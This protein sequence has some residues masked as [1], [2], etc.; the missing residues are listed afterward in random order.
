MSLLVKDLM[1]R[2]VVTLEADENLLLADDV[3][4]LGRIRHL[5]VVERGELVGLVSHRD[6]LRSSVSSIAGL[7]HSEDATIKR[8]IPV[9]EV[10]RRDVLTVTAD[11]SA[12]DAC[13][14]ILE[15]KLGC[16]PVVDGGKRLVGILTEADFVDLAR[17]YLE[18]LKQ[19]QASKL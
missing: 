1:T 6:I 18:G 14:L 13:R 5:P 19:D 8:A 9:R 7:S 3:M 2:D 4:R 16:L 10:M 17:R 11:T 12:L 15:R